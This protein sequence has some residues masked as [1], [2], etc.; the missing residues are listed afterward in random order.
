MGLV[1]CLEDDMVM[2]VA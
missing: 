1:F 2:E